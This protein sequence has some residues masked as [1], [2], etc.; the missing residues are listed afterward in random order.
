MKKKGKL[1]NNIPIIIV[2]NKN[3]L[4]FL[5]NIDFSEAKEKAL[6]LGCELLEINCNKDE[7]SVHNVIKNL[8]SK[9]YFNDLKK[10]EKEKIINKAKEYK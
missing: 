9:I 10:E 1:K 8:I 3:D 4:K 7:D 6:N 2:G 5:R